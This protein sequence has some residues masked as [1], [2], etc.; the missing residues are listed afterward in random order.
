MAK[1]SGFTLIEALVAGLILF[2]C[3][4]AAT[5]IFSSSLISNRKATEEVVMSA[6][7]SMFLDHIK[8]QVDQGET[9]GKGHWFGINFSW[10]STLKEQSWV[11]DS[12]AL[13]Q[14]SSHRA[15]LLQISLQLTGRWESKSQQFLVTRV[16]RVK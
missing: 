13:S 7:T 9:S 6:Y 3:I 11:A 1:Q 5:R 10:S 4:S 16:E 12:R 8:F 14:S 2:I 15:S